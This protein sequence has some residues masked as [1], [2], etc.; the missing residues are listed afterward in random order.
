MSLVPNNPNFKFIKG[1]DDDTKP[2]PPESPRKLE[3]EPPES[4]IVSK[5]QKTKKSKQTIDPVVKKIQDIIVPLFETALIPV[6]SFMSALE[7]ESGVKQYYRYTS[8]LGKYDFE[9]AKIPIIWN[10]KSEEDFYKRNQHLGKTLL[11]TIKEYINNPKKEEDEVKVKKEKLLFNEVLIGFG[12]Y[13]RETVILEELIGTRNPLLW[14][15]EDIV[16]WLK[17]NIDNIFLQFLLSNTSY[18]AMV[19][20]A[21]E[22]NV[23]LKI[24]IFSQ[25]EVTMQFIKFVSLKFITPTQTVSSDNINNNNVQYRVSS[26]Y[27]KSRDHEFRVLMGCKEWFK[28][29]ILTTKPNPNPLENAQQYRDRI[30]RVM[31]KLDN[32]V[33]E[34]ENRLIELKNNFI[35]NNDIPPDQIQTLRSQYW[36]NDSFKRYFTQIYPDKVGTIGLLEN[37]INDSKTVQKQYDKGLKFAKNQEILAQAVEPK[38]YVK[39]KF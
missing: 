30:K 4:P 29:V 23:D 8:E 12:P 9:K 37:L 22:L 16:H 39:L 13:D 28:D 10:C 14:S 25:N 35:Q 36:L 5:K 17:Q 34:I 32:K 3:Y 26:G 6:Y 7:A 19:L 33:K 15:K 18:G 1:N 38:I 24:I 20:A 11:E 31:T 27:Y 2:K 21:Q